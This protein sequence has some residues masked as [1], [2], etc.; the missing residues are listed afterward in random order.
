MK[1]NDG[2]LRGFWNGFFAGGSVAVFLLYLFATKSGRSLLYTILHFSEDMESNLHK[3][4][5]HVNSTQEKKTGR[6]NNSSLI[7]SASTLLE[8]IKIV[9]KS[10]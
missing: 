7:Q 4:A 10:A 2:G 3:L 6:K 5:K 1:K 9:S 8:K